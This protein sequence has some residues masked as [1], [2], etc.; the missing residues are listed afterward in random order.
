MSKKNNLRSQLGRVNEVNKEGRFKSNWESLQQYNIPQWYEDAKFGIF[1]HWGVYSVPAFGS[2]WYARHMYVEG[3]PDYM[4]HVQTYGPQSEFGYK[5]FI[6]MFKAEKFNADEWMN[7][8]KKSGAKF[9]VP[10]AEHHDGFAMYDSDLTEW[11]ASTM[12]PKRDIIGE[13]AESARK[14]HLVFGL[15]SHRA[16]NW[17]FFNGGMK[18]DSDVQDPRYAGLYGPAQPNDVQNGWKP[19]QQ[20]NEPFLDDWLGRTTEL[21]E[22]YEPQIVWFDWWIEQP[23]FKSYL[24]RMAAYYYNKAD[25]WNRGVA[26]NY[27]EKA[28]EKGTAVFDV[29]RGQLDDI[30]DEFWQTDTSVSEN[31]WSHITNHKY[32]TAES[33]IGDL[34]DIVSKNGA[35]LLNIGPRAD[36]T[37]PEEEQQMLLDIGQWL[38]VNGQAIFSTRPWKV[39]GEG[40]TEVVSGSFSDTKR[41]AFTSAD[42]RFTTQAGKLYALILAIPEDGKVKITSLASSLRL[43]NKAVE[44]VKLLGYTRELTWSHEADGLHVT[45]PEAHQVSNTFVLEIS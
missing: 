17:W 21:I 1:I 18:F 25:E 9:I 27:K 37:I 41:A 30:R 43:Y 31:S 19:E 45:L 6:P 22:K 26:I 44:S 29:E 11:K 32:K 35:L 3:T 39:Y 8:F 5:D 24:Q 42:I 38:D 7:I 12:G 13:L 23:A 20:P 15:S 2:E 10:V 33:I 4:H 16:E 40:P 28:F 36:G 14:H 34:V